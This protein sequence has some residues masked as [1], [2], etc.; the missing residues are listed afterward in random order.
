MAYLPCIYHKNQPICSGKWQ[1]LNVH[2]MYHTPTHNCILFT[3]KFTHQ[4]EHVP[5]IILLTLTATWDAF[6]PIYR[7]LRSP[8]ETPKR[9]WSFG[10]FD[11][12]GVASCGPA[13]HHHGAT[14]AGVR[15]Q[16]VSDRRF[17]GP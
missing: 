9:F 1:L 6:D 14:G 5:K 17:A 11:G 2:K 10:S 4:D 7:W 13:S 8:S 3:N 12:R 16:S 15:R